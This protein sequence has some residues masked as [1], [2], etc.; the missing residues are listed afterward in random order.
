M[1]LDQDGKLGVVRIRF[2]EGISKYL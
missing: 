2:F 1:D